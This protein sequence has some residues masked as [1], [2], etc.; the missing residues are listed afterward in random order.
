M[1]RLGLEALCGLGEI[2][3]GH[4]HELH[5]AENP[6]ATRSEVQPECYPSSAPHPAVHGTISCECWGPGA[7]AHPLPLAPGFLLP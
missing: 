1:V 7:R 6:G 4:S 3:I 2:E 5:P